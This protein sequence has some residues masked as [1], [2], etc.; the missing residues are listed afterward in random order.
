MNW[1]TIAVILTLLLSTSVGVI[2]T[3]LVWRRREA[4][5]A[6]PFAALTAALAEWSFFYALEIGSQSLD[7][8]LVWAHFQ[9]MGIAAIPVAWFL[10]AQG[11]LRH[12]NWLRPKRVMALSIIPIITSGLVF[13]HR[14]HTWYWAT[15]F[16]NDDG[17]LR[18]VGTTYGPWFM[19]FLV[20]SYLLLLWGAI[21]IFQG[22][23][24]FSRIYRWQFL[25]L[26]VGLLL[27]W[28]ANGLYLMRISPIPQLDLGPFA[29]TISCVII[30]QAIFHYRLFDLLPITRSAVIERLNAAALILDTKDRVVDINLTM[31][32]A[33][34]K[35]DDLIYGRAVNDVFD[36]WKQLEEQHAQ[37]I[38]TQHEIVLRQDSMKRTFSMQI[39]PIWNQT[40]QM[41]GRLVI[42]RDITSARLAEEAL[43]LAQVRSEFLSRVGHEL[44]TPLTSLLGLT[45]ML[46]NGV[47]D[48]LNEEQHEAVGMLKGST[49]QMIRLVND[50]L[51]QARVERSTFQLEIVEFRMKDLMER[52]VKSL[53]AS[54][55]VKG[56]ALEVEIDPKLPATQRGDPLRIYQ[57]LSNLVENAIK[58][59]VQ[60]KVSLRVF[61]LDETHF[62]MQ[63]SD[64][65]IGIPKEAQALIFNPFQ[66]AR[67]ASQL[68]RSGFGL[69]LSIV[70][71]L[72]TLMRGEVSLASETGRGS[73]F[74]ITL[75]VEPSWEEAS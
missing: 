60:G 2:L 31:R 67:Y 63:V 19:L 68:E 53:E 32:E 3:L 54:A 73:T 38:E 57:I 35:D 24:G 46:E 50:L 34:T 5:G 47:Y 37:A 40:Q 8:K 12:E 30:W 71:Q 11:Y 44:R 14:Y 45:E 42:L 13:F 59:T 51:E 18:V 15:V 10:F 7:V 20:Y 52:L 23:R 4:P 28:L 66:Q 65:G 36:W 61:C 33:F 21:T 55:H 39:T 56:L 64:T 27:P 22:T 26:L 17:P 43:A 62:A 74:T 48:P 16:L 70:K 29:F 41:T 1:Q 72:A 69:G 75:P 25:A 58:Y 6:V 49:Q 9:Y